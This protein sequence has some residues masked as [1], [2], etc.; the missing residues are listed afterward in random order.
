LHNRRVSVTGTPV[1]AAFQSL[2]QRAC[3]VALALD[4]ERA[5]ALVLG[6]SQGAHGINELVLNSLALLARSGP[7]WQW[8]HLAGPSDVAVLEQAYQNAGLTARVYPFLAQMDLAMGAA[9]AAISRAGASSLAELAAVR[10]PSVLVPFPAATDNHQFYN[11]SAFAESGAARLLE[12]RAAKPEDFAGIFVELMCNQESRRTLQQALA[13][14]YK[15]QAAEQIAQAMLE[16]LRS[17]S[18]QATALPGERQTVPADKPG[19][20]DAPLRQLGGPAASRAAA[21]HGAAMT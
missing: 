9:T 13:A 12:Q 5:V 21:L 1:R 3:R 2:D 19:C 11:A 4:P 20:G 8:L 16:R 17:G 10:L 18:P 14:W 7:T 6:G 15:P